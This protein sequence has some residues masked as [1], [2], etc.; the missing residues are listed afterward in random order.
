VASAST[1]LICIPVR[2]DAHVAGNSAL[3]LGEHHPYD[4]NA[5]KQSIDAKTPP[6]APN[7]GDF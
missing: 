1:E 5:S 3:S 6:A 7:L 4:W 2:N